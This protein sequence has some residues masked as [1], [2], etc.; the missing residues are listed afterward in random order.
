MSK[1]PTILRGTV[2]GKT[3]ELEA[4]SGLP[5]GQ[6]V[7]V[8]LELQ[9]QTENQSYLEALKRAAGSWS[10]DPEGLDRFLEWNRQQRKFNR[11]E[12]RA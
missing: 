4:E 3:I 6:Q 9:K 2:H 1:T 8:T 7:T 11:R 5:E 12:L 10:D